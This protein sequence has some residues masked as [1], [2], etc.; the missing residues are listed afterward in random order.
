MVFT[1]PTSIVT[2]DMIN[3]SSKDQQAIVDEAV[4]DLKT[5]VQDAK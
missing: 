3:N 1:S 5:F 4:G 2:K